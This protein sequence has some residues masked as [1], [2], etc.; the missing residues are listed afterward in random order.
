MV[1]SKCYLCDD[2]WNINIFEMNGNRIGSLYRNTV[3]RIRT[4]MSNLELKYEEKKHPKYFVDKNRN[5][6]K[7]EQE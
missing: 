3:T 4:N 1:Q 2:C 7:K 6:R 5:E